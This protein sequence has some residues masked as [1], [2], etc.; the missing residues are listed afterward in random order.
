VPPGPRRGAILGLLAV[1]A[2]APV[3]RGSEGIP[4][5]AAATVNAIVTDQRV[6]LS[7]SSLAVGTV[8][9]R[10]TN[11][12]LHRHAFR[13][14]GKATPPVAP[15]RSALLRVAFAR[16]GRARYLVPGL[17]SGWL[18]L[19]AAAP[20]SPGVIT[21]TQTTTLQP[22]PPQ[23]ECASPVAS[24]VAVTMTDTTG[25]SGYTFSPATLRCGSTTFVLTNTG[26]SGHGLDLMDPLGQILPPSAKVPPGQTISVTVDLAYVGTYAW[27]DISAGFDAEFAETS[28]GHLAVQ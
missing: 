20:T 17:P 7:R 14:A 6:T 25:P 23:P 13:I 26:K 19:I 1:L 15:G 11:R 10:V 12:G 27:A 4:L 9:F 24:T 8:T 21:P 2:L 16:P 28:N 5:T 18:R 22:N 3:A